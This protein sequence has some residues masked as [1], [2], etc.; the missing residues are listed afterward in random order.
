M[1][2]SIFSTLPTELV[3][4][5]LSYDDVIR[6][7]NGKYINR[8]ANNDNRKELLERIPLKYEHIWYPNWY[9]RSAY[10]VLHINRTKYYSISR[11]SLDNYDVSIA[12]FEHSGIDYQNPQPGDAD[13]STILI[14][15]NVIV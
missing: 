9:I 7:R 3:N 1:N 6:F 8:I 11:D 5:I 4:I 2:T 14:D 12:T 10:V 15:V 13:E